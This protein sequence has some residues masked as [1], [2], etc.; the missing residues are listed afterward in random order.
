MRWIWEQITR[1][2]LWLEDLCCTAE[3]IWV[4][5]LDKWDEDK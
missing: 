5:M 1:F 2:W 3:E 4:K